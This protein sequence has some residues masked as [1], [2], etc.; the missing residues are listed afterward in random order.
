MNR[1]KCIDLLVKAG[2]PFLLRSN[3]DKFTSFL[4]YQLRG[5]AFT[6]QFFFFFFKLD[7]VD[8]DDLFMTTREKETCTNIALNHVI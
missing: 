2:I 6:H 8:F 7:I 5:F 1:N 3:F 4:S